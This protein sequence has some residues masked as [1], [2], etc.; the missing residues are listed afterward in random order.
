MMD[1][2]RS[3]DSDYDLIDENG[4]RVEVKST[5]VQTGGKV[6]VVAGNFYDTAMNFGRRERLIN[7]QAAI[8]GQVRSLVIYNTLS[9]DCLTGCFSCCSS[10]TKLKSLP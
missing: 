3:E 1:Y 4:D 9:H 6:E 8:G 5:K 10:K 7:Q 2:T